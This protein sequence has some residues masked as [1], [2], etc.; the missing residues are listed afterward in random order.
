MDQYFLHCMEN[1][2]RNII[3]AKCKCGVETTSRII[4]GTEVTPVSI[5]IKNIVFSLNAVCF[6][7]YPWMVFVNASGFVCG[8]TLVAS[9]YMVTAAH[10]LFFDKAGTRPMDTSDVQVTC[11]K[12]FYYYSD[13]Y[14]YI[15][16]FGNISTS[17]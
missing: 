1:I 9:R 13:I 10:C 3:S 7:Q 14:I 8:G 12:I 2:D 11:L 4:E 17:W 16:M 15:F 5:N 6:E